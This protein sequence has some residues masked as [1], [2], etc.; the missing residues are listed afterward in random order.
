MIRQAITFLLLAVTCQLA[1]AQNNA[2]WCGTELTPEYKEHYR[3]KDRSDYSHSGGS[4]GAVRYVP[5]VY[6]IVQRANGTDGISLK[7]VFISHCE[8]NAYYQSS[9]IQFYIKELDTIKSDN[10][11]AMSTPQGNTNYS[12]G[13]QTFSANNVANSCN[14]YITGKLPGLC[15]FA[16][17]P[18]SAGS[19]GGGIFMNRE[20]VGFETK[21]F[22]HEM[23]HYFGLLHTFETSFGVE[24]V[25]GSNCSSTG[26]LFCDTPADFL[27]ERVP[28]PYTGPEVD[29]QGDPYAPVLDESLFMS[30]F[31]DEC[32]YRFSQE[33][34]N[35][36]N[37]VLT[38]DR[39]NLLN[40]TL[41]D[42][43][44]L[45]TTT[46]ISPL[47]GDST[48]VASA[49][50][51]AWNAVQG[52]GFYRLTVQSALSGTVL[53]D[54]VTTGTAITI[55]NLFTD[56]DYKY[57]IQALSFGNACS[58]F[59]SY[60]TFKTSAIKA[61]FTV[62]APTCFGENNGSI[63]MT[64][65]G[66]T[67]PYTYIWSNGSTTQDPNTLF[68]GVYQV[69]ITDANGEV[70]V[71]SVTISDA[72]DLQVNIVPVQNNLNAQVSG[73][74][75]PYI[76]QWNNGA[77]GAYNTN[78][79]MG[80]YSVTVSDANGCSEVQA[81]NFNSINDEQDTKVEMK[82]F[83]NPVSSAQTLNV[84]ITLTNTTEGEI[85]VMD[86]TGAV[87][88]SANRQL[89]Q[90]LNSLQLPVGTLAGGNYLVRFKAA[91]ANKTVRVTVLK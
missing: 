8:L 56:K 41:P 11:W 89:A 22:P 26:D 50:V 38:N 40:Q 65:T 71:T 58:P 32:V 53:V 57:R 77:T 6:H 42:L 15:G 17:F 13:Y 25:D 79:P 14:V 3:V 45:D 73:G 23:G 20:C 70:A 84:Q 10:I 91:N 60:T 68:A 27:D 29:P 21:T 5:V 48:S 44:E 52:A 88:Y 9:G 30:Y 72:A 59:N 7:D 76:Y 80:V 34:E 85:S 83:P 4:R 35:E 61:T 74:L 43:T 33:E 49:T 18:G 24:F 2:G 47:A 16:T 62:T 64:P 90:G 86:I 75:P 19:S 81:F 46:V 1:T 37:N 39:P 63:N 12:L 66:G 87:M 69:T 55:S 67:A 31:S 78:I 51:F 54:T 82:V 36:M 28:C